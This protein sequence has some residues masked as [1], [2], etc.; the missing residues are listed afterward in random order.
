MIKMLLA[1]AF[2]VAIT[3]PA[4]ATCMLSVHFCDD[5]SRAARLRGL[6]G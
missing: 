5:T 2:V 4:S 6:V 3:G 1:A